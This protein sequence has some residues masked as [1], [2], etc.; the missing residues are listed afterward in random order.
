VSCHRC[1]PHAR[2]LDAER[3][4]FTAA[5][6]DGG[7]VNR[8]ST[9]LLPDVPFIARKVTDAARVDRVTTN[10]EGSDHPSLRMPCLKTCPKNV[11][12]S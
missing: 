3:I 9:V 10:G 12:P 11:T 6:D 1:A 8:I 7:A 2:H 5:G 4:G